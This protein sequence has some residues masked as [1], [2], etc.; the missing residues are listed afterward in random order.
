MKTFSCCLAMAAAVLLLSAPPADSRTEP[1]QFGQT[2]VGR[3]ICGGVDSIFFV[4]NPGDRVLVSMT[5]CADVGGACS[6]GCCCFDQYLGLFDAQGGLVAETSTGPNYN[7][8]GWTVRLNLS[9]VLLIVGG[10]Y[11]IVLHDTNGRGGGYYSMYIQ[12]VSQ[13][14]LTDTLHVGDDWLERIDSCGQVKSYAVNVEAGHHVLATMTKAEQGY[15]DPVLE[16]Y[17]AQGRSQV[18]PGNGVIDFSPTTSGTFTLLAYSALNQIGT[19][20]IAFGMS[21]TPTVKHSWGQL[22][23]LYR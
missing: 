19:Y 1:I 6:P 9:D 13:P 7:S 17:D 22:K 12:R 21:S 2:L 23:I 10:T 20:R 16:L 11:T 5:V 8:C 14:T 3:S 18:L 15:I 4:A